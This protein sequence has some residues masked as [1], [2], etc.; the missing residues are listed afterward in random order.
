[1]S[2]LTFVLLLCVA[3]LMA[4]VEGRG[5]VREGVFGTRIDVLPVLVTYAALRGDI[6]TLLGLT[7]LAGLL[8]DALSA[9]PL[10]V[11][12]LSLTAV[13]VMLN[14][15]RGLI[16]RDQVLAQMA[17]GTCATII[18]PFLNLFLVWILGLSPVFG[19]GTL[20]QIGV[21]GVSGAVLAPFFF[22]LFDWLEAELTYAEEPFSRFRSEVEIKRG[23]G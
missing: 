11:S 4:F 10:G 1:M 16:L 17:L 8:F 19:W 9:N 15:V 3:G 2:R 6:Y 18:N 12:I 13:G 23:R 14:Q 22:M 21:M 5:I 7:C 20:F